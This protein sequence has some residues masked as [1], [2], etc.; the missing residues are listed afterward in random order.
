MDRAQEKLNIEGNVWLLAEIFNNCKT[1]ATKNS[2]WNNP[3]SA[4]AT[5]EELKQFSNCVTKSFK[6]VA[7]F[8]TII[9]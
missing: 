4:I 7:L 1:R 3:A 2:N 8:P 6:G 5:E 9:N